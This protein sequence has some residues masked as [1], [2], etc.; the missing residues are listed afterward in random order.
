MKTGIVM[1]GG[2]MRGMFT[3]GVLDVLMENGITFDGAIGVSAGATFGCNL[4]SGQIGRALRYNKK[5]CSDKRYH[6]IRSLIT[7]G[8]IYNVPF[9]YNELPYKLDKWDLDAFANSPMEFY[10]VA[11]DVRTGKA[12]YHKCM[13][14]EKKDIIWIQASASMPLVSRPVEIDGGLYL[15][16]GTSDSIPLKFMEGLGYDK[17][18]VI[19]T[20]PKDYVKGKQ[21]FMPLIKFVFRKYPD[22]VRSMKDRHL[23]YNEEKRY[24][25]E[26][27]EKGEI[28][29]I[30]PKEPLNISPI[31]KNPEELERVY[32]LGRT[33][34]EEYLKATT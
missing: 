11:T 16:G 15:D 2:A 4:K 23:M 14:G 30:R 6:S 5:Y 25:R 9:C 3:C 21:K 17:I 32:Q 27:E 29:V 31:E 1:E 24:I 7:T 20:Q 18:L 33:A 26:K 13:T 22:M 34:G 10:C 28:E 12:V 19:E 8:D